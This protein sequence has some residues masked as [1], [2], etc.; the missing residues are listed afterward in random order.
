MKPIPSK[1]QPGLQTRHLKTR[2][3]GLKICTQNYTK[4]VLY[5]LFILGHIS[6]ERTRNST[7]LERVYV[8]G[9]T[10]MTE[11]RCQIISV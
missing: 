6:H 8:L 7:S 4:R 11:V 9:L 2:D 3:T 10:E 1:E 5:K